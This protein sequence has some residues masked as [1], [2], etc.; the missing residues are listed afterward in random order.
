MK[1]SSKEQPFADRV[2]Y[3]SWQPAKF[4]GFSARFSRLLS[5][6][7]GSRYNVCR[8]DDGYHVPQSSTFHKIPATNLKK[9][10]D[11]DN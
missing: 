9:M 1:S 5:L 3:N 6:L 7:H 2:V 10:P 11:K 4:A 8:G